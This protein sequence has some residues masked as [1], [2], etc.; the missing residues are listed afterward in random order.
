[1]GFATSVLIALG[2][3]MDAFAVS[4][5]AGTGGRIVDLGS[6]LR[7]T[8]HFGIFQAGMTVLGWLA[9][10]T[11][12]RFIKGVDHWIALILLGYIGLNMI[13]TALRNTPEAHPLNPSKGATMVILSVA[14]SI[15][16]LAVGLSLAMLSYAILVPA[17]AIGLVT[18]GLSTAGVL[19][20]SRLGNKFGKRME[21]IGGL[22]LI[23]IGLRVL[24][25]DLY[26][27]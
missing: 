9:G 6:K 7:L 21:I 12:A 14:T 5:G 16:A 3:A 18:F 10:S 13:R 25:A 8:F 15:D 19:G 26:L 4:V 23:G 20:G 11:L 2:L 22:I 1:M 24:I 27:M 17:L